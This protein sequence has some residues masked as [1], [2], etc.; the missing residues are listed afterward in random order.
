MLISKK[1]IVVLG[2][3]RA[4]RWC[5]CSLQGF[6]LLLYHNCVSWWKCMSEKVG[7]GGGRCEMVLLQ[8]LLMTLNYVKLHLTLQQNIQNFRVAI[9]CHSKIFLPY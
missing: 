9:F 4:D 2:D 5:V 7:G 1:F 8:L 3:T 6:I